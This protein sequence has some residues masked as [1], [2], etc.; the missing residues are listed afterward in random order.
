MWD[1]ES[2]GLGL[3]V[4]GLLPQVQPCSPVAYLVDECV[5]E[6]VDVP[7]VP[8]REVAV[9][10]E[11]RPPRPVEV[12][13]AH[14]AVVE[15]NALTVVAREPEIHVGAFELWTLDAGIPGVD[16][17]CS[18]RVNGPRNP[19]V[20]L[21]KLLLQKGLSGLDVFLSSLP[22]LFSVYVQCV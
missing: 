9:D 8:G 12:G 18:Q 16:Q 11:E 22:P 14:R 6:V 5:L 17:G 21:N 1:E 4:Q 19:I 10:E 2:S 13:R 7:V 20:T 3:R 15:S